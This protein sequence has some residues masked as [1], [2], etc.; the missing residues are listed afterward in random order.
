VLALEELTKIGAK[1]LEFAKGD[2]DKSIA[3]VVKQN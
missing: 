1:I 3:F 2:E